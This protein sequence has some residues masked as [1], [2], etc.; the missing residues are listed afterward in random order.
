MVTDR[1]LAQRKVFFKVARTQRFSRPSHQQE[2]GQAMLVA[3][4]FE[5]GGG[6]GRRIRID[7]I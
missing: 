2:H 5:R 1:R 3:K 6:V 4:G 7:R